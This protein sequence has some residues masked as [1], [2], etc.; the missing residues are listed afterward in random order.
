MRRFAAQGVTRKRAEV[1][2][3]EQK[4]VYGFFPLGTAIIRLNVT[5]GNSYFRPTA[6][7]RSPQIPHKIHII[8]HRCT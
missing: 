8:F 2:R 1:E 5:L 7:P 4:R 6:V 3:M